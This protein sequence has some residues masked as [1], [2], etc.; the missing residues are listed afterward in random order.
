MARIDELEIKVDSRIK[1]IDSRLQEVENYRNPLSVNGRLENL[2]LVVEE[3]SQKLNNLD[4]IL[5]KQVN[6]NEVMAQ[7]KK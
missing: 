4:A 3:L 1:D 6:Q 7:S 2:M 5:R